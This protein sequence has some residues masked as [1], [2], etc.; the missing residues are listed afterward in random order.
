MRL[1]FQSMSAHISDEDLR[2]PFAK[3]IAE[4]EAMKDLRWPAQYRRRWLRS[5]TIAV[6][7]ANRKND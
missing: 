5:R 1:P 7:C 2:G 4:T 3:K 6:G